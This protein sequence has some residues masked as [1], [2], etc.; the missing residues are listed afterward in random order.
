V[1]QQRVQ[2]GILL[3]DEARHILGYDPLP[4][5]VG[6]IPQITPVGGAPNPSLNGKSGQAPPEPAL[7]GAPT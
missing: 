5:G 7:E 4:G 3:I 1:L 2:S 6:Q